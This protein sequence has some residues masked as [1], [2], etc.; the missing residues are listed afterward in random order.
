MHVLFQNSNSNG[1][2]VFM[3]GRFSVQCEQW[4]IK[5]AKS[6]NS[7]TNRKRKKA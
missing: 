7:V 4:M 2:R 6:P 1:T 3:T 5:K